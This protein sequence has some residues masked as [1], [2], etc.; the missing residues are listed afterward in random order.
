MP[1]E[2]YILI[3]IL[4]GAVLFLFFFTIRLH[5]RIGKLLKDG[6]GESIEN[7]IALVIK[8]QEELKKFKEEIS[9]YLKNV[10]TRLGKSIQSVETIRFNPF[11][12]AG[13]SGNQSFAT[14]FL[15][16]EG[17]GVVISSI[18]AR[19]RVSMFAKPIKQFSSEHELTS[20]EKNALLKSRDSVKK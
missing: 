11:Q 3:Y 16:E 9:A 6:S 18:Y 4:S 8:D 7:S 14:S 17:D 15:N 20:E 10:E 19:D 12:E 2:S 1:T 13:G 5:I